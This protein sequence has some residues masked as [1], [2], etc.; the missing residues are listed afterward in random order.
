[1]HRVHAKRPV[2]LRLTSALSC[3]F[4]ICWQIYGSCLLPLHLLLQDDDGDYEVGH[5]L[6][7]S[8]MKHCNCKKSRCLK[9]YCECFSA[10]V[11]ICWLGMLICTAMQ[12]QTAHEP[13]G[14][15]NIGMHALTHELP[16]L[17]SE[18]V[19][20]LMQGVSARAAHVA[21]AKM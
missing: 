21:T 13:L 5:N 15:T 4:L 8:G 7:G 12:S 6:G 9:L 16:S 10:G 11:H 1:M 14:A 17:Q 3:G 18:Q 2:E 20:F 19:L